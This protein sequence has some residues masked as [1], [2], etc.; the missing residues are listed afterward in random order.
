MSH[1]K[2]QILIPATQMSVFRYATDPNN[3]PAQLAKNIKLKWLNPGTQLQLGAEYS[4]AMKRV[5]IEQPVRFRVDRLSVGASLTYHQLEG[6]FQVW[7][8]TMKFEKVS[9]N[10]TMMT[11]LIEYEMPL[12]LMGRVVDDFWWRKD[13]KKILDHR[14]QVIREH[15][16]LQHETSA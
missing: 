7:I 1:I 3:L 15:F 5:G 11:D 2:A 12:G 9:A 10:E 4:F 14:L 6:L 8:H 16:S 13:L